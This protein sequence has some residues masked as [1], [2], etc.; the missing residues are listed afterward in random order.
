MWH[1]AD[2]GDFDAGTHTAEPATREPLVRGRLILESEARRVKVG[3]HTL[4][5]QEGGLAPKIL[6]DELS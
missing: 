2:R 3:G 1:I 4:K 5:F 6:V